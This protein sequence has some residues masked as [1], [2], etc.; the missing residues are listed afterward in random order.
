MNAAARVGEVGLDAGS[1]VT[2]IRR[3]DDNEAVAG[4]IPVVSLPPLHGNQAAR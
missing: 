1:G 3:L 4:K 2:G